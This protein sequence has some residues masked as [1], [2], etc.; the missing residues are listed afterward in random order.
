MVGVQNDLEGLVRA[1]P[2]LDHRAE[3]IL[4]DELQR[5]A[6]DPFLSGDLGE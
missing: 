3:D 2:L 5:I 6:I 4:H 1:I